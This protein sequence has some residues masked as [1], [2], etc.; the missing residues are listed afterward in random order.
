[1]HRPAASCLQPCK[2]K[3][4]GMQKMQTCGLVKHSPPHICTPACSLLESQGKA[5]VITSMQLQQ[6]PDEAHSTTYPHTCLQLACKPEE[7]MSKE[8]RDE[9]KNDSHHCEPARHV[10]LRQKDWNGVVMATGPRIMHMC[11]TINHRQP[12]QHA[13][14]QCSVK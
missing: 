2:F 4:A 6:Q 10:H 7:A 5:R 3:H 11:M 13:S 14:L 8:C 9:R 12:L 1:M